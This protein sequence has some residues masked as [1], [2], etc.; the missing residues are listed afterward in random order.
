MPAAKAASYRI[1]CAWRARLQAPPVVSRRTID[2]LFC[3]IHTVI[4]VPK[5]A[6][7][8][9]ERRHL[10]CCRERL[11]GGSAR[12]AF[13][14]KKAGMHEDCTIE[15]NYRFFFGVA[16]GVGVRR[17][18]RAFGGPLCSEARRL[19]GRR[20]GRLYRTGRID[21]TLREHKNSRSDHQFGSTLYSSAGAA[22]GAAIGDAISEGIAEADACGGQ[23]GYEVVG[24]AS[25]APA[26]Q[27]A[28]APVAAQAGSGMPAAH[29]SATGP[30]AVAQNAS[31]PTG[32]AVAEPK[33]TLGGSSDADF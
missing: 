7:S 11:P 4:H 24:Q 16:S 10:S 33:Y 22:L 18:A 26:T 15:V 30:Q 32:D 12:E 21:P 13:C 19:P 23:P 3:G 2:V 6:P 8:P 27:I 5:R 9:D 29:Q 17:S 14:S 1:G 28:A 20:S 31:A 25:P